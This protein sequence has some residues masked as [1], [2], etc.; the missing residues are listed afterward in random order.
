MYGLQEQK[1]KRKHKKYC[2]GFLIQNKRR[3]DF[4]SSRLPVDD[5]WCHSMLN[6]VL[7]QLL[8]LRGDSR[9]AHVR[10]ENLNTESSC[11]YGRRKSRFFSWLFSHT[12]KQTGAEIPLPSS[13]CSVHQNKDLLLLCWTHA[14]WG[15]I[16]SH[17]GGFVRKQ[18][19]S[20]CFFF[21]LFFLFF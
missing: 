5:Y 18:T 6:A 15:W 4:Q 14:G 8:Q 11:P 12:F 16:I 2:S 13:D 20:R 1:E 9:T 7:N 10:K 3:S 19:Q 21:V 17:A